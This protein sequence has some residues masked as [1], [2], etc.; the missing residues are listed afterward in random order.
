MKKKY[1]KPMIID[2]SFKKLSEAFYGAMASS[3]CKGGQR[4]G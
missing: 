3:C 1:K 4:C 2:I